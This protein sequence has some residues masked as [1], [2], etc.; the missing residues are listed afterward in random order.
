MASAPSLSKSNDNFRNVLKESTEVCYEQSLKT[1][2]ETA[3]I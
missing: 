1:S 2:A 3:I